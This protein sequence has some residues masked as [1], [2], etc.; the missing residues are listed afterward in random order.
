M[1]PR[2][3]HHEDGPADAPV[4]VLGPS[5]GTD[6]HL[7]DPQL[8]PARGASLAEHHRVIRYDLPGHG[9]SPVPDGPETMATLADGV[10]ELLDTLGVQ[11]FHYAGIS[12]GGAIG[13]QLAVDHPDRVTTLTAIATAARFAD[14]E[15]WPRRAALVR[16]QGTRAMIDSREGSGTPPPSPTP[17]PTRSADCWTCS[18]PPTTRATRSA[19][20]PSAR[21][22]IRP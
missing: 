4:L 11:H 20:R 15:S 3:H 13:Q 2:L 18:R 22:T 14:P 6:L 12:I 10:V 5:L 9:K 17:I 21:S 16:Q 19:A 1:S 7:F 8:H